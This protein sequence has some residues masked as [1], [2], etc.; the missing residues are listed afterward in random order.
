MLLFRF[1]S[2]EK[3]FEY[4]YKNCAL[5][6]IPL[7]LLRTVS[8]VCL[9]VFVPGDKVFLRILGNVS[10]LCCFFIIIGANYIPS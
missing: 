10:V 1:I 6:S 8:A 4:S 9:V 5:V 2:H 3:K 7:A